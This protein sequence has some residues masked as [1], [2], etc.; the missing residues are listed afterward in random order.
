MDSNC[1]FWK[2]CQSPI[3][4]CVITR[5][6]LQPLVMTVT[7]FV[8][9]EGISVT[10][11]SNVDKLWCNTALLAYVNDAHSAILVDEQVNCLDTLS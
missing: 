11:L 10:R 8:L 6:S 5:V 9:C 7:V 2:L 3:Q 1:V 4:F